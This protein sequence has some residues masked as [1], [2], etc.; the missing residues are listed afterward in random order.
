MF[1]ASARRAPMFAA[2]ARRAPMFGVRAPRANRPPPARASRVSIRLMLPA[3]A[4][5]AFLARLDDESRARLAPDAAAALDHAWQ[6]ARAAWPAI[7]L[8]PDRF[9]AY[10]AARVGDAT[11]AAL[12]APDL[13]LACACV[14][15]VPAAVQAFDAL[16]AE[17][18]KRLRSVA[19]S[20]QMLE[21]AKQIARE[22]LLQRGDRP[23]ALADYA[24]RGDLRGWLRITLGRELVRLMRVDQGIRRLDTAE[25]AR[26]ADEDDDPETAYLRAHYREEFKSAFAA[27]IEV[28]EVGERRVLRYAVIERLSIDDI[29]RLE[30]VHRATAA[31]QVTRARA[32]LVEETRRLLRARLRVDGSQLHSI[33]RLIDSQVEVSVQRLLGDEPRGDDGA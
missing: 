18:A 20:P 33:L 14:A 30:R 26:V 22:V 15:E 6:Q 21:D 13:Y 11:L 24:G 31:R 9:C 16:L 10:L 5:A 3:T 2:S 23:P 1:A 32:R 7:A 17:V 19:R 27:A 12:R 28:L 25:L 29:A 8:D 4:V